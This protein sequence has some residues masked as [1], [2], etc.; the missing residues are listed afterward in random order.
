MQKPLM[1][2]MT[3]FVFALWQVICAWLYQFR[4]L[5]S[6]RPD[7]A[8]AAGRIPSTDQFIRTFANFCYLTAVPLFIAGLVALLTLNEP[9]CR[10]IAQMA[11]WKQWL[12]WPFH[13][14]DP[15]D[16]P[17]RKPTFPPLSD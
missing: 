5:P 14:V 11:R 10:H 13:G 2:P 4:L 8:L 1:P 16:L 9:R 7:A 12:Y 15:V 17:I 6:L 3:L